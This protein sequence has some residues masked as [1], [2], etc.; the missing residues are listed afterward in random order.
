M[1]AGRERRPGILLKAR[2]L[3]A[4]LDDRLAPPWPDGLEFYL[5]RQDIVEDDWLS[6]LSA[7]MERHQAPEGFVYVVEGPMRA[8]DGSFFDLSQDTEASRE[9]LRRTVE[10]GVTVGATAAVIHAIAPVASPDEFD[11]ERSAATLRRALPLLAFYRDLCQASGLVPT[12]ENIPPV[13]QMREARFMHSI[14]GM[15]PA[16]L[17]LLTDR[18][19]GVQV[20]LD[21][22]HAQLYLNAVNADPAQVPPEWRRLVEHVQARAEARRLGDYVAAL[23][24][25]LFEA[26]ISNAAGLYGEG[27]AYAEGDL[28][29]DAV[30]R[31]LS[32]RAR[33]LITETIEPDPDR[34]VRMRE[35]QRRIERA[36]Y[37]ETP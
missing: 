10:F 19:E 7:E 26:H 36:L 31:D 23:D 37:G 11:D 25:R 17:R 32:R 12:V 1:S 6:R 22:S 21:V 2:P 29:L 35:A 15:E 28:D 27:L 13:A 18:V 24:G 20:T 14:I 5:D 34:A 4:Q 30:V 8:L 3:P 16:D 9:T 33:F